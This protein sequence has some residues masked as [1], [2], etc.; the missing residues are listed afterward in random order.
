MV[1]HISRSPEE[2]V[3]LGEDLGKTL[4][5]GQVV[6]L[7]GE[8]G[9][10]KTQFVKGVVRGLGFQGRIHSPTFT[11]VN[12]YAW[13]NGQCYHLDLYRLE[14][15]SEIIAAGLE[16]YAAQEEGV[17]IIEWF[18]RWGKNFAQPKSGMIVRIETLSD[19]ER[20]ITYDPFGP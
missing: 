2:T 17:T 5:P 11:L 9:A 12:K 14:S 13:A 20:K 3:R 10:G 1:T 8:L 18:D 6:G 7:I 16:E 15:E 19:S 4:G